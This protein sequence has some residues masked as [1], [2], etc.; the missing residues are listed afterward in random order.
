MKHLF[1]A[2][3]L[4]VGITATAQD[5]KERRSEGKKNL[6]TEQKVD[7]QVKKMTK[8]LALNEKQATEVRTLV[9]KQ[10][11]KREATKEEIKAQK[12]QKREE[13]KAK[14][15]EDEAALSADMKKILTP[16]QFTK[17]EK[18]RKERIANMKEKM[19]ERRG[20]TEFKP[21]EEDK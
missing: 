12:A 9:T 17:W 2:L 6:T 11:A 19:G 18:I 8:D 15:Q 1:L 21:V 20:K 5:K 16:E 3:L 10:V 13:A 4:V 7:L 14:M